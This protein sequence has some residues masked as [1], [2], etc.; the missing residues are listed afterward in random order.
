[1]S[2]NTPTN[3]SKPCSGHPA[4]LFVLFLPKC[5]NDFLLW[6]ACLF[7][8][9]LTSSLQR[10]WVSWRC[11]GLYG[12]YTMS[13][14]FTRR[15]SDRYL[16]IAGLLCFG[17]DF[18]PRIDGSWN[19]LFLYIELGFYYRMVCLNLIWRRFSNAYHNHPEKKDGAY[20]MYYSVN[21]GALGIMLCG[22]MK[23]FELGFWLAGFYVVLNATVLFYSGHIWD[24]GL[25]PTAS[26][27]KSKESCCR[28]YSCKCS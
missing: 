27:Q 19:A 18:G 10:R 11:H 16:G 8:C 5:G 13:V 14:Y 1:M 7:V 20:S 3:F 24:I 26:K 28:E 23:K 17:N 25:K 9:F 6:N 12:T 22:Y 4:G 2:Q 21:A 15:T